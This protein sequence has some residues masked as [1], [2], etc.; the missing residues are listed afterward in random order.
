MTE[1]RE[2]SPEDR[3]WKTVDA[4]LVV[5]LVAAIGWS[6]REARRST[7]ELRQM[8]DGMP[9]DARAATR[10]AFEE[11]ERLHQRRLFPPG[12]DLV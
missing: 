1:P 2:W 11:Q 10:A 6:I 8:H 3:L 7:A 5:C 4:V 9:E 12:D